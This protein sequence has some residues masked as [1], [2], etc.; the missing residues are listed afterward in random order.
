MKITILLLFAALSINCFASNK[1]VYPVFKVNKEI[2][3]TKNKS[4]SKFNDPCMDAALEALD[5]AFANEQ[6]GWSWCASVQTTGQGYYDCA[7]FFTMVRQFQVEYIY[8]TLQPCPSGNGYGW[9]NN[10]VLAKSKEDL[11][12]AR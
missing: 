12:A 10:K 1:P 11:I 6:S 4:V 8:S 7:H 9:A 5:Q 2:Q 3:Q